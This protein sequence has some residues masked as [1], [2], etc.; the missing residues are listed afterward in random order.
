MQT[1]GK[2]GERKV[3]REKLMATIFLIQKGQEVGI[4][5]GIYDQGKNLG[6]VNVGCDHDTSVFAV[7]SIQSWWT[8]MGK[9]IYPD[10]KTFDMC[11]WWR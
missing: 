10:A 4:P 3:L 1:K 9:K 6:W 8:Y 5:Y 11:R 2:N 7:Q